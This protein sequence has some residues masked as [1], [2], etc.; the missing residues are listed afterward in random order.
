[1]RTRTSTLWSVFFFRAPHQCRNHVASR[2]WAAAIPFIISVS[3]AVLS[4]EYNEFASSSVECSSCSAICN[5]VFSTSSKYSTY[6]FRQNVPTR[7]STSTCTSTANNITFSTSSGCYNSTLCASSCPICCTHCTATKLLH[8]I[9]SCQ[10]TKCYSITISENYKL[11]G[12]PFE[13]TESNSWRYL[14]VCFYG[15]FVQWV[16]MWFGA[17]KLRFLVLATAIHSV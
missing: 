2:K 6:R 14:T 13:A 15:L 10:C 11:S 7:S 5:Y 9:V 3:A 1:M 12:T 4:F 17:H 8:G 16:V